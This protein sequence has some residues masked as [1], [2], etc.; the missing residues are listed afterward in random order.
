MRTGSGIADRST[1][2][3]HRPL[4][5]TRGSRLGF[6]FGSGPYRFPIPESQFPNPDSRFPAVTP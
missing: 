3:R 4:A 5:H 1:G 2:P 6:G